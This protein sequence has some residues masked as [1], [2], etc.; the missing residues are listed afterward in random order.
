M[1]PSHYF[2]LLLIAPIAACLLERSPADQTDRLLN[3]DMKAYYAYLPAWVI[4]QDL[5]FAF[6]DD[7]EQKYYGN[8]PGNFKEFRVSSGTGTVNKVTP[9]LALLLLP[10][11]LIAHLLSL[12]FGIDADG[13]SV[14][15]QWS[16]VLAV[17]FYLWLGLLITHKLLLSYKIR[18]MVSYIAVSLLLFAT[19]LWY[20]AAYDFT[21][22][23]VF[24]FSLLASMLWLFRIGLQRLDF[25]F[26]WLSVGIFSVLLAIRPTHAFSISLLMA[27]IPAELNLRDV[28]KDWWASFQKYWCWLPIVATV[29]FLTPLHWKLQTGDWLVYSYGEERFYWEEPK[30]FEFLLSFRQGW[31]LYT[32]VMF[33]AVWG[34]V[35][36]INQNKRLV[37]WGAG[38]MLFFVYLSSCW[39]CWWYGNCFGQRPMIDYYPFIAI[40]F[41]IFLNKAFL[42]RRCYWFAGV[43][44]A[45]VVL[46]VWQAWQFRNGVLHG[47]LNTREHYTKN[48]FSARPTAVSMLPM[49]EHGVIYT[50]SASTD[51]DWI[52]PNCTV[53]KGW[54][55]SVNCPYGP[56]WV[57]EIAPSANALEVK[58]VLIA[59]VPTNGMRLVLDIS[60]EEP[61]YLDCFMDAFVGNNTSVAHLFEFEGVP[62]GRSAKV[63]LWNGD[64]D[65]QMQVLRMELTV[66]ASSGKMLR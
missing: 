60:G 23:H 45:L 34:M 26:V 2:A 33:F 6:V 39:W 66:A 62:F 40:F 65:Q 3:G 55:L 27:V 14:L 59:P 47:G 42:H 63:Y 37:L 46:N 30:F 48:F 64:T 16:V 17:W 7:Y 24:N 11:F 5:S 22:S 13:Y 9:G 58:M 41:A 44:A 8:L 61:V 35:L 25:K 1:R 50:S 29:L 32:P 28:F 53:E 12:L 56:T 19:N 4:H 54:L 49:L 38:F 57:G 43:L 36:A 18:P 20:Y 10:F 52:L 15:Y 21:V 31:L 51:S